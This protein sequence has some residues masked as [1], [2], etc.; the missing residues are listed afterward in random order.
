MKIL[1]V[2]KYNPEYNRTKILLDGLKKLANIEVKEMPF[3]KKKH[4]DLNA[5][6][7]ELDW[8]D[9][10]YS[11]AFSHK[12][13]RFI[14]RK[15]NKP[16]VFDPL[17]SNYLTKVFDYKSVSRWS[18]RAY[19]NY[20]KDK[21]PFKAATLLISDTL[22]HK[23]YFHN[24]F[25]IPLEKIE[26]LPIGANVSDFSPTLKQQ[27]N[28]FKVGFYGGFIPLQ[29]VLKIIE[30]AELL[31]TD[32]SI[33]FHLIGTGFQYAEMKELVK[34]KE[35]KN[36]VFEGWISYNDLSTH[37]DSYDV[38]LGIFGET[39]KAKLVI[40]NKIYHYAAMGKPI[41][42]MKTDAISEV[43][44]DRK[45]ILLTS[46]TP[47]EIKDAIL[48]LKED[49]QLKKKIGKN[50]LQLIQHDMNEVKIAE[51]FVAILKEKL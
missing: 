13:V 12:Y 21:L 30:A 42:T 35:L 47:N 25:G 48:S 41:I 11:P 7:K 38:C 2:G 50:A 31:E 39:P 16:L 3:K 5:L 51:R 1:V 36:V 45:N 15:T 33:Q 32:S 10:V 18:P 43:F 19:K 29:G 46:N 9:I 40:P 49:N 24:T 14:K 8:C 23:Y 17:I 22:A 34:F 20:L 28:I 27:T 44:T 6:K 4:L 26:V 37:I